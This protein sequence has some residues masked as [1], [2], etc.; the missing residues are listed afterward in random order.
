MALHNKSGQHWLQVANMSDDLVEELYQTYRTKNKKSLSTISNH[1]VI[2]KVKDGRVT[3]SRVKVCY[4]YQLVARM[5]FGQE[6]MFR[7]A[8]SKQQTDQTISHL[9]G[10]LQCANKHHMVLETKQ[11][12]DERTICHAKLKTLVHLNGVDKVRKM[13]QDYKYCSH[14]PR[15]TR[16]FLK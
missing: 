1:C 8:A 5:K 16:V 10:T 2:S 9:C 11:V 14:K 3:K 12:N 7:V 15:C 6:S 13:L 4:L